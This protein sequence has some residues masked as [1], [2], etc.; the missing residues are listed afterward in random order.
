[1]KKDLNMKVN[2]LPVL[3]YNFLRV[4]DSVIT[5][6]DLNIDKLES[7]AAKE[8]PQGVS[9]ESKVSFAAAGE[10]FRKESAR[11]LN[12]TGVPGSPNGDT[13]GRDADQALRTG[14]GIDVDNLMESVGALVDIYTAEEGAKVVFIVE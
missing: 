9:L 6:S 2:V 12:S 7:P 1:M 8:L 11:I 14:M 10:L 3:T 4:N 5:G 13:S